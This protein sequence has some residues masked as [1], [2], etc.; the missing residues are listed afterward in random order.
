M[1]LYH[2]F[3]HSLL[4]ILFS[5]ALSAQSDKAL[6]RELAEENKKS[7]EALALYPSETRLAILEAAKHPELLIK[8]DNAR[9]KT[10]A[11]FRTLIEDFPRST[12]TV[13]YDI[14]AYPGLVRQIAEKRESPAAI[15]EILTQLP[16]DQRAAAFD[17]V[18]S[19]MPTVLKIDDLDYTARNTF[20]DMVEGYPAPAL[21]AFRQLIELPEVL[22]ILNQDIR[23]TILVGD[24]YREDPVGVIHMTDSLNLVVAR[25]HAE[26]L[27]EWKESIEKDPE[28]RKELESASQEYAAEYGYTPDYYAGD[29]LYYQNVYAQR[30]YV[31]D[32][33]YS[34][35]LGYPWWYPAP[36]WQPHPWWYDSGFYYQNNR[37]Q[38]VYMPSWYFM[39]W[40]F[41]HPQH[42]SQYSHLSAHFVNHYNGHRRSGTTISVGVGAWRERNRTVISEEWLG[43]KG[44]LP[45]RM[46]A[47]GTFEAGRQNYN[48]RNPKNPV[49]QAEYLDK[50]ARKYPD[51]ERSK[52]QA[53]QDI[54]REEEAPQARPSEWAPRKEPAPAVKRTEPGREPNISPSAKPDTKRPPRVLPTTPVKPSENPQ[55]PNTEKQR[56]EQPSARPAEDAKDY[57]RQQWE[58]TKRI[59]QK[60]EPQSVPAPRTQP[61]KKIEPNTRVPKSPSKSEKTRGGN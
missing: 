51:L 27:A 41:Y 18:Q 61:Q 23:F 6:L 54:R 36:Y 46:K 8:M 58:E 10:A 44:R 11:A 20:E 30:R 40:Y 49:T 39:D 21:Q 57:H 7:V 34:W 50:N 24:L 17:V 29:D 59:E 43:D 56:T 19:Q 60:R 37:F 38:A 16:E 28:A 14:A 26:E 3:R 35:W 9:Q 1:R 13:F 22:E 42:H 33:H 32:Y 5:T 47:F 12:Q 2:L 31:M 4:L 48:A 45:E 25:Q 55:R 52:T 53:T 15:R